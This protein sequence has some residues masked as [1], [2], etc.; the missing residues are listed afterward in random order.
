M[1]PS[2]FI[3][4]GAPTLVLEDHEYTRFLKGLAGELPKPKAIVLFS[5]HW[6]S[7]IPLI[8]GVEQYEMIYDFFG[9]PEEMY[10][11][12]YPAK[13]SPD[14]AKKIQNLFSQQGI[15]SQIDSTRGIDHGAW[16]VLK[17]LYPK[18]DIP[19]VVLSVN[20][21]LTPEEQY[22]MG[23]VLVGLREQDV[24]VI[25][26]GGTVHNLRRV[27]WGSSNAEDW[28]VQF[29]D[30]LQEHIEKWDVAALKDYER[31]APFAKEAVPR[32]EH[33][34]PLILAMG[35]ADRTRKATLKYRAYQYGNLS[36]LCWQFA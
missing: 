30:W 7:P 18:A 4:H 29:D 3:A 23:K 28:A 11:M 9:F 1:M 16:V 35:A 13:G 25:G 22:N 19:V 33:F 2:L 6:E 5:A 14:L 36:L 21:S 17:L 10:R 20:P 15:E 8:S 34:I 32:N 27:N 12:N 26:S 24:L 31:K